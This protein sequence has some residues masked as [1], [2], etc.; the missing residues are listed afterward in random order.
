MDN[1]QVSGTIDGMPPL[2]DLLVQFATWQRQRGFSHATIARRRTSLTSFAA[3]MAPAHIA[4]ASTIDVEEWLDTFGRA[5]TRHAY[6]SD[7]TVFFRWAVRRRVL[8]HDPTGDT[9]P[10]KVPRSLPRPVPPE[11]VPHLVLTAPQRWVGTAVALAAY[12]GLRRAEV[13]A[14]DWADISL[15]SRPP[16]LVVRNGKG[17]KDR[18]VPLHPDLVARLGTPG[19]GSVIDRASATIGY[20]VG[21]HLR[22][23]GVA[24]SMHQLRHTFGTELARVTGGNLI[25]TGS[26]MGHESPDTTKGYVGWA[27]GDASAAVTAM[28]D[29][30]A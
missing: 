3:W 8:A 20:A 18:V 22:A 28:F 5:R 23:C 24:A 12:A 14:L 11:L 9:D 26:L 21:A 25:L 17:G 2:H 16:V 19:D 15:H 6:R 30:A 1:S 29:D 4:A 10:I 13:A 27:G 7:L